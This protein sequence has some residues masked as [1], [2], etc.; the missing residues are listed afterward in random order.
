[1]TAARREW[2]PA[3]GAAV[4]TLLL[5]AATARW[6]AADSQVPDFDSA[7]HLITAW[8]YADRLGD[9]DIGAPFGGYTQYPPLAHLVGAVGTVVAGKNVGSPILTVAIVFAPLLALGLYRSGR[10]LGNGWT[11]LLAVV[12]AVG[13]P[14]IVTEFRAYMLEIPAT[15]LLAVAVWLLIESRRFEALV[16]AL[17]AGVAVGLGMLTK[18]SFAFFI[19][20]FVAVLFLRGGWRNWRGV[21]TFA[22][23]ALLIGLPW[24]IAHWDDLRTT[25]EWALGQNSE[26]PIWGAKNLSFY[27]WSFVNREFMLPLLALFAAGATASVVRFVRRPSPGDHTPELVVGLVVGW[28][29]LTFYL[30]LKSPYYALPLTVFVALL[31]TVWLADL[32][33]AVARPVAVGL[34]VLAAVNFAV[35]AFHIGNPPG[36]RIALPKA[37]DTPGAQAARYVTVVSP[38]A[39]PASLD[40]GEHG[41]IV[42]ILRAL[43]KQGV[44]QVEFDN[45]AD[46][47]YYNSTGL[48]ALA[49]VAGVPRPPVY[50]PGALQAPRDA[51]IWRAPP[52][53]GACKPLGDG[54]SIYVTLGGP[55]RARPICPD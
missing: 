31:S 18:Q 21:A 33:P 46:L 19:A 16:P 28:A 17:L 51:F 41:D 1:M 3:A 8:S 15:A 9:W 47:A 36:W 54:T 22:A 39:W 14:M 53:P 45:S 5:I 20:G 24:Y 23:A 6:L 7:K 4:V 11:G 26:G 48:T 12:F 50:N 37:S 35:A 10:L 40:A 42:D 13:T 30:K 55:S 32:R 52:G 29:A 49:T 44:Q 25:G 27:G 34:G 2:I 43:K 38:E